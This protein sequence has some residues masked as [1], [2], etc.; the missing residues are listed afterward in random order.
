MLVPRSQTVQEGARAEI[1]NLPTCCGLNFLQVINVSTC[2][3]R[4]AMSSGSALLLARGGEAGSTLTVAR[5]ANVHLSELCWDSINLALDC[6]RSKVHITLV[7]HY[8]L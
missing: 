4:A 5:A 6:G 1:V 7:A 8:R 3:V 2:K